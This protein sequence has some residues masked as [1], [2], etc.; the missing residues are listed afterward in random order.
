MKHFIKLTI[1]CII[2]F[3]LTSCANKETRAVIKGIDSLGTITLD[4]FDQ[5]EELN[6]SYNLLNE[7]EKS[8]V[9]NYHL[10]QASIKN[11]NKLKYE[12]LNKRIDEE[13]SNV[14]SDSLGLLND[15]KDEYDKLSPNGKKEI[16]NID[17]LEQAIQKSKYLKGYELTTQ[18][19]ETANGN[20]NTAKK[21]LK[22]N[23]TILSKKQIESCLIEIGRWESVQQAETF[24]K[25]FLKKPNSYIRYSASCKS[26]NL[27]DNHY[28][29]IVILD[30]G[31]SNSFNAII[32]D[33]IELYVDFKIDNKN[34]SINFTNIDFTPFY[35][36]EIYS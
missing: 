16:K 6:K 7:K 19:I 29:T 28:R 32:R 4:S 24:F 26:P 20:T 1:V 34:L 12:D 5:I 11:Y 13:C 27:I 9:K 10:L 30:Y 23:L 22:Q 18:I 21:I 36:W 15:L 3:T 2:I 25:D 14:T 8:K 35:K 33:E 17:L 31:A